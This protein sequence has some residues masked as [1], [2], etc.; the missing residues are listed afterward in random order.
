MSYKFDSYQLLVII[1]VKV[2]AV[3][4]D[5]RYQKCTVGFLYIDNFIYFF[6]DHLP[7]V[8]SAFLLPIFTL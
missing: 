8:I 6:I 7:R 4:E 1:I 5:K 2:C 3:K